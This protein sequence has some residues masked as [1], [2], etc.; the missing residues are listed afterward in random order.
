VTYTATCSVGTAAS[1]T[2]SNT[3]TVSG[4][5]VTD[6]D[7]ANNSATDTDTILLENDLA[8]TKTDGVTTATPGG[9]LVYT[10][11]ASNAGPSDATGVTVADT[12]P[13]SLTCGWTCAGAGGGTCTASGAGNINDTVALPVGGSATYTAACTVA[14]N[15]GTGTI[16][17]TATVS[18]GGTD[19]VPGNNSATDTD[20]VTG[21]AD[22]GVTKTVNNA[23]P[24]VST[25]VTYTVTATNNG[26]AN[27]TGVVVT[28]VLPTGLTFVSATPSQ[29]TYTSATGAWAVGNLANA[30]SATLGITATVT[31]AE[32]IV[33]QATRTGGNETD[34]NRANNTGTVSI[35]GATLAD[36][37]VQETADN[38]TPTNGQNVTFTVT[39]HNAGPGNATGVVITDNL[40]AG[41]TFVSATASQGA[42]A[43]ATGVWTVGAINN[44]ATAT[45]TVVMTVTSTL[46]TTRVVNKTAQV[47]PD[48]EVSND[49]DSVT[50]NDAGSAD[51]ALSMVA[52]QEPVSIGTTFTYTI[53]AANHGPATATNVT[54]TDTLPAGLTFVSVQATQ[55]SCT[56]TTS[57]TCPLGT[58]AD[59]AS[60]SIALVVTKTV[61]GSVSNSASVT[62]TEADPY[63][64][65]NT[66]GETTTPVSLIDFKV[67]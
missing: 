52:S 32:A 40:P 11:T 15:V 46:P 65:N 47:E 31:R 4:G 44:G 7:P 35:N 39:A 61:G 50:L 3:A 43:N 28:D 19:P 66:N 42:Y 53:V 1:G 25:N 30:A 67:Q 59:G 56:G 27:A 41:L 57:I 20:T 62:A 48:I 6:P 2:L 45:L 33:N 14:G 23:T 63:M 21:S 51:L 9:S 36:V 13:A 8:I 64:V 60:A 37:Q 38:L 24:P 54:V 26:P 12:F 18:G 49:S 34:P 5:A 55:G 58:L 10:I 29:G 22:I 17:N 16:A